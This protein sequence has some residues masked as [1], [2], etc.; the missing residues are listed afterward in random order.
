[1]SRGRKPLTG[2]R[3]AVVNSPEFDFCA[4]YHCAGDCGQPHSQQ[5]RAAYVQHALATFDALAADK[6]RERKDA[7][8]QVRKRAKDAI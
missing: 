8:Q 1:M 3:L 6:R 2:P 4:A 7:E 5:E